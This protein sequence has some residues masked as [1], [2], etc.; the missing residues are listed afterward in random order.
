MKQCFVRTVLRD[1]VT[2]NMYTV[3]SQRN[4]KLHI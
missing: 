4:C 3:I 2:D 1:A